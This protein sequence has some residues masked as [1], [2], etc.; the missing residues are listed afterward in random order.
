MVESTMRVAGY[1]GIYAVGDCVA[2]DGPKL[3]HMAVRQAEVAAA[4]VAAELEGNAPVAHYS[5]ELK[6]VIDDFGGDGIY[7]HKNLWTDEPGSVRQGGFWS[8]AKRIQQKYWE[9]SHS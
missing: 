1:N 3:G 7:L 8:W 6:L 5:H 2:F 4:N 9:I